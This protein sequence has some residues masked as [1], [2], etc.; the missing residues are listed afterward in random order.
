MIL[1]LSL[2][3]SFSYHIAEIVSAQQDTAA[4]QVDDFKILNDNNNPLVVEGNDDEEN[5]NIAEII[6]IQESNINESP[7][8]NDDALVVEGTTEIVSFQEPCEN[9]TTLTV[10]DDSK[11]NE[12]DE[13]IDDDIQGD[14]ANNEDGE[15]PFQLDN[16]KD[17]GIEI[18]VGKLD[19]DTVEDDLVQV[20]QQF[21]ELKSIRIV[22]KQNTNKSKGFAFVQFAT[23]DQAKRA[24]SELKDGV[25]VRVGL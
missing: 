3:I 20:F 22:R 1:P 13:Q 11:E 23:V 10:K 16:I 12:D 17:K 5:E 24:L 4:V 21:G 19:K 7:C 9:N 2:A 15:E 8:K 25:E 6:S 14:D 18:H